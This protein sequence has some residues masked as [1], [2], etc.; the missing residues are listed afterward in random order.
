MHAFATNSLKNFPLFGILEVKVVLI[1]LDTYSGFL[2]S[3]IEK[4]SI[5]PNNY[6]AFLDA[7]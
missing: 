6:I 2:G 7:Y 4:L 5:F 1:A 3:L